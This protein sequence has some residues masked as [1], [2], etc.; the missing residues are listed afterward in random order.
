MR[1]DLDQRSAELVEQFE[2]GERKAYRAVLR[3]V[4][5]LIREEDEAPIGADT[6]H[7]VLRVLESWLIGR[8]K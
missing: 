5:V 7:S 4:R 8:D 3:K 2:L 1:Q 6:C